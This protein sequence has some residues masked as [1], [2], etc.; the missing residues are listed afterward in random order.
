V[1]PFQG[2]LSLVVELR[3]SSASRWYVAGSR[4]SAP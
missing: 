3:L 1:N 2:P 4:R